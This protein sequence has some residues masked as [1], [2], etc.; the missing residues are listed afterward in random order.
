MIIIKKNE[1]IKDN[2][3]EKEFEYKSDN[4]EEQFIIKNE[5]SIEYKL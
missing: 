5:D 3:K 4:N 1:E 2:S